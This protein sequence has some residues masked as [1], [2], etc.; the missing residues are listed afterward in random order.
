MLVDAKSARITRRVTLPQTLQFIPPKH[1]L[2]VMFTGKNMLRFAGVGLAFG[3]G[4]LSIYT[5]NLLGSRMGN[6]TAGRKFN[7]YLFDKKQNNEND[8]RNPNEIEACRKLGL[9]IPDEAQYTMVHKISKFLSDEEIEDL[10]QAIKTL[11]QDRKI[12]VVERNA[13]GQSAKFND[14][15]W[16]TSFL[17]TNG[18]FKSLFPSL[19]AKIKRKIIEVDGEVWHMIKP[20]RD[21]S[22][23]EKDGFEHLNIRTVESHEYIQG[24]KLGCTKHYDAGSI[25]TI[26]IMLSDPESEFEG[27]E[28]SF[29]HFESVGTESTKSEAFSTDEVVR[30]EKG[31]MALFLSHKYHNVLPVRSGKRHVMVM[32]LWNGPEKTCPH[33]CETV[34]KCKHTLSRSQLG[35]F[36]QHVSLLG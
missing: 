18:H 1:F 19:H 11:Q 4:S 21:S 8:L 17:H 6:T 32:E 12:G 10:K 24:G 15:V 26:D 25:V 36:S 2:R 30:L 13:K 22:D 27:G 16:R 29:P 5:G 28:L 9:L 35:N 31:D 7:S 33:R 20:K 3:V 14:C 23:G 34:G